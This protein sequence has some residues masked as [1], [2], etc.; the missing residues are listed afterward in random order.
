MFAGKAARPVSPHPASSVSTACIRRGARG[1]SGR[2]HWLV[3]AGQGKASAN[4]VAALARG[5][6]PLPSASPPDRRAQDRYSICKTVTDQGGSPQRIRNGKEEVAPMSK[7]HLALAAIALLISAAPAM[8]QNWASPGQPGACG[9]YISRSG[10]AVPRPCGDARY[11]S[12][13]P[14]S[15]A[16]CADGTYSYSQH[17]HAPGTCSH[18]G[19]VRGF[20]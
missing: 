5:R 9:Y 12:P 19:G 10:H 18:H 15:T 2:Y 1:K 13:P 20:N 14:G 7:C 11:Q 17:P 4:E 3:V 8:A 16:I 6:Q